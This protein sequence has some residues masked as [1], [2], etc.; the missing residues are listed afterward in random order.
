MILKEVFTL[1]HA[2]VIFVLKNHNNNSMRHEDKSS[3][4]IIEI[5]E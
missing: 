1:I 3:G 4:I 5:W 2:T